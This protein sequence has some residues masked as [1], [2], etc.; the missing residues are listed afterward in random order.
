MGDWDTQQQALNLHPLNKNVLTNSMQVTFDLPDDV[1]AQLNLF[2]G[3]LTEILD[4]GV[5]ELNALE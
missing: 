4:L 3:K 1:V 5:W 2:E